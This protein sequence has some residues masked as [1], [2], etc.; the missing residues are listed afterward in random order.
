MWRTTAFVVFV[1]A[2]TGCK[3]TVPEITLLEGQVTLD[4]KP[5][6]VG[7]VQFVSADNVTSTGA[8]LTPEGRYRIAGAPVGPVRVAVTTKQ[9]KVLEPSEDDPS[10][11]GGNKPNPRYMAVPDKYAAPETSG[12]DTVIAAG[13]KEHNIELKSK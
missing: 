10:T 4:G 5:L 3:P 6:K 7:H 8:E 12:L 1:A 13:Q 9:F 11:R 2:A